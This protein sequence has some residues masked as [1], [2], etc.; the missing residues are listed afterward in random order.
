VKH[1]VHKNLGEL[2]TFRTEL[3]ELLLEQVTTCRPMKP[4]VSTMVL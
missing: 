2:P 4:P 1:L 3:V